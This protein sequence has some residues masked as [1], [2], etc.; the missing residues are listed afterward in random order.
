[1]TRIV[2]GSA[3]GR[4][5]VVPRGDATRPTSDRVRE[6]LFSRLDHEGVISGARVLDLYA[7][8]GALGLEAASRG[9]E[10]VWLVESAKPALGACRRNVEVLGLD[11]VRVVAAPVERAV[12]GAAVR[13]FDLV[14]MD[15]PYSLA[16]DVLA[17]VLGL[18]VSG[19]WLGERAIVVVERSA[20]GAEP[21]W[22]ASL[23]RFDERRY[24][25]T[26]IW[27]AE[28]LIDDSVA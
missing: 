13:A 7:G 14:L 6:A 25:E 16:E 24:G 1:M 10:E 4:T 2:A 9:A 8:S 23:R 26:R 3:R 20:R 28:P 15:P 11:G 22:P 5:L 12:A 19:G 27:F 18:L 21:T 17:H